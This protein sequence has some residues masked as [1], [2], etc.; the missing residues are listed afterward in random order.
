MWIFLGLVSCF[1]LGIYDVTKKLSLNNNA[2]I[3]VLFFAS[4]I[5]ALV[6]VPFILLSLGGTIPEHSLFFVPQIT[7]KTH[8]LLFLKSTLVGTSWFFAYF[9]LKH[10][11]IT[12]VMPIRAT[13]P[14]WTLMGAMLIYNEQYNILQWMGIITVL[15]FFYFFS[16]SG[17]REGINFK[18]NKWILFIMIATFLGSIS[19]LY[20]KFL[21]ANYDRMA[22][23]A[24]FSIYLI[25]VFL[26]FM[27]FLWYLKR[28]TSTPLQW[29]WSIPLIGIVLSIADFA[30]FYALTDK[31]ALI[32]ILS[33][34]R[35]TSVIISFTLGAILFKEK[36]LKRKAFALLGILGGV[37]LIIFGS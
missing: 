6:F 15:E 26:P 27:L 11:P 19:T 9:A 3:P 29:R 4:S 36:N 24:W 7:I 33:V 18:R 21:V 20:D 22:I 23:Q 16:L 12:I 32:T 1:F 14:V 10:L 28:K 25:P 2:V 13:G 31:D 37:L 30:Y 34:L 8:G 35:R 17:N 5:G